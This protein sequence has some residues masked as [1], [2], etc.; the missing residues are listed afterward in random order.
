M[1][2]FCLENVLRLFFYYK[3]TEIDK[4]RT[5]AKRALEAI[6][7]TLL[8]ERLNIWIALLN[9]ENMLG[10]KVSLLLSKLPFSK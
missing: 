1:Y 8:E 9:L 6:D 3:A 5:V 7:M 2:S 10:S 4:A